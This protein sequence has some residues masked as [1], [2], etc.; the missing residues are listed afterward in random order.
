L[1]PVRL[2]PALSGKLQ[3]FPITVAEQERARHVAYLA[4]AVA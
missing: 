2:C 4:A 1:F 3:M